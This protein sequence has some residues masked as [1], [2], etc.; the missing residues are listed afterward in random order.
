[1]SDIELIRENKGL[2]IIIHRYVSIK[3]SK[4][5]IFYL[6]LGM[7]L[8]DIGKTQVLRGSKHAPLG[9][10]LIYNSENKYIE[11][12]VNE[13]FLGSNLPVKIDDEAKEKISAPIFLHHFEIESF[14][15]ISLPK[16]VFEKYPSY[17]L[18]TSILAHPIDI[19]SSSVY[20]FL[21]ESLK[22][23]LESLRRKEFIRVNPFTRVELKK[24]SLK[25]INNNDE[26]EKMRDKYLNENLKEIIRLYR[27]A[28]ERTYEPTY[29]VPLREHCL[30]AALLI[31]LTLLSLRER[32][33]A[34]CIRNYKEISEE[35]S[36]EIFVCLFKNIKWFWYIVDLTAFDE[37]TY[38]SV[39]LRDM[40]AL[41]NFVSEYLI[42]KIKHIIREIFREKYN[43]NDSCLKATVSVL[44]PFIATRRIIISLLPYSLMDNIDNILHKEIVNLIVNEIEVNRKEISRLISKY[45]RTG[46][47]EVMFND[48]GQ[49]TDIAKVLRE[50]LERAFLSLKSLSVFE[51]PMV[52][53]SCWY[54]KINPGKIVDRKKYA[55]GMEDITIKKCK[56]CNKIIESFVKAGDLKAKSLDE[57]AD[58]NS[59]IALIRISINHDT[60]NKGWRYKKIHEY[61]KLIDILFNKINVLSEIEKNVIEVLNISNFSERRN[62]VGSNILKHK[63]TVNQIYSD[64]MQSLEKIDGFL[65]FFKN[66]LIDSFKN[67][68]GKINTNINELCRDLDLYQL[69]RY[70]RELNKNICKFTKDNIPLYEI[71]SSINISNIPPESS[72]IELGFINHPSRILSRYNFSIS[73]LKKI[74][75]K[76]KNNNLFIIK[77]DDLLI[78]CPGNSIWDILKK[79]ISILDKNGFIQS[80]MPD[81]IWNSFENVLP[82]LNLSIY[83]MKSK[84]PLYRV[85]EHSKLVS[86]LRLNFLCPLRVYVNDIR[87]GFDPGIGRYYFIPFSL[88]YL[89]FDIIRSINDEDTKY[90]HRIISESRFDDVRSS[91]AYILYKYDFK[92]PDFVDLINIFVKYG[93]SEVEFYYLYSLINFRKYCMG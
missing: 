24:I 85:L 11:D 50:G 77:G 68:C 72:E 6:T 35:K 3:P 66:I 33:Y 26:L 40:Y 87:S 19:I 81:L 22:N 16:K 92:S 18:L 58:E 20:G 56:V 28:T 44:I 78:I 79:I 31:F 60:L 73:L 74:E 39:E 4:R 46:I 36:K 52:N 2:K 9:F 17:L 53:D 88:F 13:F 12:I 15:D 30:F 1:M 43:I 84:Y 55:Y 7:F 59:N 61:K 21:N 48:Y 89:F 63:N 27:D 8:H 71:Y 5:D 80:V 29:D 57:Y 23:K 75:S 54:C 67:F 32:D 91:L 45:V 34:K 90:V 76:L 86:L 62:E 38:R 93:L 83:L 47:G 49:V 51:I 65:S 42:E 37:I 69:L 64:F 41:N 25:D 82:T 10:E 14:Y 70:S